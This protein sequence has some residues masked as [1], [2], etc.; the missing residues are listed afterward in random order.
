MTPLLAV[1]ELEEELNEVIEKLADN[2][3]KRKDLKVLHRA[4]LQERLVLKMQREA[5]GIELSKLRQP[6]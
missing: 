1:R 6:A 5:I 4:V 3:E 2:K